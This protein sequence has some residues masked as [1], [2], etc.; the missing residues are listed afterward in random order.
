M[1][2]TREVHSWHSVLENDESDQGKYFRELILRF[3]EISQGPLAHKYV[4][5]CTKSR[6]YAESP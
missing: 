6:V 2:V 4:Q 1:T 3:Y 5:Y